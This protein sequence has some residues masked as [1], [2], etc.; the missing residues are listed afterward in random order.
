MEQKTKKL[1][2][3]IVIIVIVVIIAIVEGI[4]I[5]TSNKETPKV[6]KAKDLN[7][8]AMLQIAQDKTTMGTGM[9]KNYNNYFYELSTNNAKAESEKGKYF[10]VQDKVNSIEKDYAVLGLVSTLHFKVYLSNDELIKLKSGDKVKFV[11]RL[12]DI[13]KQQI[14]DYGNSITS[15]SFIFKNCYLLDDDE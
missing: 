9:A 14:M 4:V 1:D 3:K 13:E 15:T 11:G 10:I 8:D 6:S 2:F 12:E 5:F 7:K